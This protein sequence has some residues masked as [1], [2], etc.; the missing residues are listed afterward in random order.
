MRLETSINA[1]AAI[2]HSLL[3]EAI[4]ESDRKTPHITAVLAVIAHKEVP[5]VFCKAA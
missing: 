3:G 1:V 4:A 2:G 5:I